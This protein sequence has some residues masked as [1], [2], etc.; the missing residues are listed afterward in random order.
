MKCIFFY[1][2]PLFTYDFVFQSLEIFALCFWAFCNNPVKVWIVI[3]Y[4]CLPKVGDIVMFVMKKMSW[5]FCNFFF[6]EMF[7]AP[8]GS[9]QMLLVHCTIWCDAFINL[10][11]VMVRWVEKC[12]FLLNFT[13]V[14]SLVINEISFP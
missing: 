2:L 1:I 7:Q 9:S 13:F 12:N 3:Q 11:L 5:P 8:D 4:Y 14:M 6:K 10:I